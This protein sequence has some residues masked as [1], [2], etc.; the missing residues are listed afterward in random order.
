MRDL[1]ARARGALFCL[2]CKYFRRNLN[3]GEGLRIYKKLEIIGNGRVVIGKNCIINGI[4]GDNSQ[5]VT[6]DTYNSEAVISIGD[7]AHLYAAR[8]AAKFQVTIGNDVLIEES[9]I[10]D[11]DFHSIDRSRGNPINENKDRCQVNIGNGVCIGA[12][13]FITKGV[14]IGD[15]VIIAPGSV[16]TTS[17]KSGS[18]VMGNPAKPVVI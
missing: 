4:R 15:N 7:N 11:T 10:T 18:M 5:Y 1:I 14:N 6:I 3:V 16:V 2:W 13:S 12:R 17:A 8:I 9:G